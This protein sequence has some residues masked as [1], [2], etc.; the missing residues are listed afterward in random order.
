M[1]DKTEA[2]A[3]ALSMVATVVVSAVVGTLVFGW[4]ARLFR[5]T[6]KAIQGA[7]NGRRDET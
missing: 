4:M 5:A 7:I 2:A 6:Y 1:M 3:V